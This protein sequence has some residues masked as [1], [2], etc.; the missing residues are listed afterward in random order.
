MSAST[1]PSPFDLLL[2]PEAV[3][4]AIHNSERLNRLA[5]RVCRPL[6]RPLPMAGQPAGSE[7][8]MLAERGLQGLSE[9]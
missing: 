8:E 6:D 3:L 7:L 1:A 5:S 9:H 2:N 4:A